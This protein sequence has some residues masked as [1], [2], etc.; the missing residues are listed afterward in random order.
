[1]HFPLVFILKIRYSEILNSLIIIEYRRD[2]AKIKKPPLN[3][4]LQQ[5]GEYKGR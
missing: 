2:E 1:M 3:P 5:G 4:L